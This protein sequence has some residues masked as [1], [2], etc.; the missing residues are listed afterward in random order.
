MSTQ[1][2]HLNKIRLAGV[3]DAT[4]QV[5]CKSV[6]RFWR[7][8]F[9]KGFYHIWAWR[10]S[11]SRDP[12]AA[13]K[14][15][16]PLPNEAPHKIWLWL[17]KRFQRRRCLKL[18]TTT[19][20]DGRTP[21]HGYTISSPLSLRLRWAKNGQITLDYEKLRTVYRNVKPLKSYFLISVF[22]A[23][24]YSKVGYRG[25]TFCPSVCSFVRSSVRPSTIH[26][27]VLYTGAVIGEI[28]KPCIVIT[29]DTLFKQAPWPDALDLPFMLHW[30]CQNLESSLENLRRV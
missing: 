27:K 24:A 26:A 3:T 16:F 1:G 18:W 22:I 6:R 9:L 13:N 5:S 11:C 15:S 8:R 14:L 30:L 21:D 29:L 12:H 10:P 28:M 19:D 4:Y 2:H 7:R 25:S 17:A 23:S 20:D